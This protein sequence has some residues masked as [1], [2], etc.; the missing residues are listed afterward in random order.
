MQQGRLHEAIM[1]L[2]A[3]DSLPENYNFLDGVGFLLLLLMDIEQR[4]EDETLFYVRIQ[5]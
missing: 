4:R 5:K 2:K 3:L 1:T